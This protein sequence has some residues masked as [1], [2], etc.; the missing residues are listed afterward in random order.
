LRVVF[1]ADTHNNTPPVPDGDV[2]VHAG[3]LTGHGTPREV[4]QVGLWLNSLPHKHKVVIPGN[5]DFLFEKDANHALSLL[6]CDVTY[7]QESAALVAGLRIWG[8]PRTPRFY[9]WAFNVDRGEAIR[10]YWGMIPSGL[11]ILVTHGPPHGILDTTNSGESAGC[12][13]LANAIARVRPRV[14]AFGH[15]H[16]PGGSTKEMDG[17]VFVNCASGYRSEHLPVVMDVQ[18]GDVEVVSP[19]EVKR[20]LEFE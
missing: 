5:H 12:E 7:L 13:E 15:I 8:S 4:I 2:L 3:D 16:E 1:I 14:H 11:D 6:N 20:L 10:R 9:D 17:T 18:G 19:P